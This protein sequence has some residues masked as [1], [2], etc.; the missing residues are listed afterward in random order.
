M[1]R[2]RYPWLCAECGSAINERTNHKC[3]SKLKK[4]GRRVVSSLTTG[5][6][7]SNIIAIDRAFGGE[8]VYGI[9]PWVPSHLARGMPSATH[10]FR[11]RVNVWL[12]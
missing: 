8:R 6:N 5:F 3:L 2:P 10:H 12:K 4:A 1:T 7:A 9:M 11:Y